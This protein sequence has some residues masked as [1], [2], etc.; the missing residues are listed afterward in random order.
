MVGVWLPPI[1]LGRDAPSDA[2]LAAFASRAALRA[3]PCALPVGLSTA[4]SDLLPRRFWVIQRSAKAIGRGGRA[5]KRAKQALDGFE[6]MDLGWLTSRVDDDD[7]ILAICSRQ[8][9]IVHLMNANVILRREILPRTSSVTFRTTTQHV[10][11][12]EERLAVTW[13]EASDEV[14]FEVLSFSR[15]RHALSWLTFPYVLYQQ[16][17]FARDATARMAWSIAYDPT[18]TSRAMVN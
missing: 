8:L 17:R 9:G 16:R 4:A 14:R 12:G 13:D 10:L 7:R 11:A 3:R 18:K 6:C 1:Q 5:Y 15:P 2:A